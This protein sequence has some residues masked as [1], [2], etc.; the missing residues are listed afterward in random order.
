M[1]KIVLSLLS[2]TLCHC[3]TSPE[4]VHIAQPSKSVHSAPLPTA[5]QHAEAQ[6]PDPAQ[7]G[8]IQ[9]PESSEGDSEHAD[10]ALEPSDVA[11]DVPA[12]PPETTVTSPSEPP[13]KALSDEARRATFNR[14]YDDN[15][16]GD[17]TSRSGPGSRVE[18]TV[19]IRAGLTQLLPALSI[20][21]M[22]DAACGDF[23]WMKE[24][25]MEG[26]DYLGW[27]ISEGAIQFDN[28][29]YASDSRQFVLAD[30]L[31]DDLPQVDLVFARDVL[32]HMSTDNV[33]KALRRIKASGSKYLI[34]THFQDCALTSNFDIEDGD[35]RPM[36]L[37][38]APFDLP[39]PRWV[40]V[41][42]N[43]PNYF[44]RQKTMGLWEIANLPDL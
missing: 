6:S 15:F 26:I 44:C 39:Q 35:H 43:I 18:A 42:E 38:L 17:A 31:N 28:D 37:T 32:V 3:G 30:I 41:E 16:W 12:A 22:L 11:E 4:A 23:W 14:F 7:S 13:S 34:T 27:D 9:P 20:K 19:A 21:S 33:K 36:D 1:R 25:P 10:E 5:Q 2:L 29:H 24:V 8:H 40:V